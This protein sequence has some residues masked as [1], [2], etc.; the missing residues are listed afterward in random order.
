[1]AY[2]FIDENQEEFGLRW[3]LA[4]MGICVNA[5]YNYLKQ[6]KAE[7]NLQKEQVC[8]EIKTV[9]HDLNGIV[10]HRGMQIFLARRGIYL[11]KTTIHKYMNRE[12]HLHC[13]C[14]RRKPSYK[15]GHAHKIFPNILQQNFEVE[16][17]NKVWCT[18]FTYLYLTNGNI[19]YNCTVID[20]YDRSVVSSVNDRFITSDLAIKAVDKAIAATGCDPKELILHSDQGSQFTTVEFVLHCQNLGITQSMSRA[21]TPYDNAAM[22]RYYNTLKTE[23][24]YQYCFDT[25]NEFDYAIAEFVYNALN[26]ENV[27]AFSSFVS[28]STKRKICSSLDRSIRYS[29][30]LEGGHLF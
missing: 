20:L 3:L 2:R 1:M 11:S 13:I 14:R 17:P 9:Y 30:L 4:H 18:D 21:G 7:Y 5:Y 12:M 19:R 6:T 24:I 25:V 15:K 29:P 8:N 23:L 22:E 10:G 16:R 26:K 27:L 28:V